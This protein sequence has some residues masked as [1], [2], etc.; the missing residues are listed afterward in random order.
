MGSS[1]QRTQV[2]AHAIA[3][4]TYFASAIVLTFALASTAQARDFAKPREGHPNEVPAQLAEVTISPKLGEKIDLDAKFIDH[5]GRE[6][7][8][9]EYT[10]DGKP[11]LLSL[12]YYS[13]PRDRKSVV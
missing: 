1:E 12:A 8:L 10:K 7:T 6:V 2:S 13:C 4:A 11:I 9:R 5:T 3:R